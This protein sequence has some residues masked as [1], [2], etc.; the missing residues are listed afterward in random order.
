MKRILA[1]ILFLSIGL[2]SY[3]QK[4]II[5]TLFVP[6][7]EKFSNVQNQKLKF[8]LIKTGNSQIDNSINKDLKD[9]FTNNEFPSLP[10]DSAIIKWADNGIIYLGFEVTYVRNGLLS[11]NISAEGCGAYC[12]GWTDYFTYNH[13][14]GKYVTI[15]EI[16]DTTEKFRT[17]VLL[18]KNKQFEQQK[19][20]LKKMLL[21]KDAELDEETYKWV[22]E[23]FETCEKEFSLNTFALYNDHLEIVE[24]CY[25]PNAIKSFT[26]TIELKYKYVDINQY[27]KIKN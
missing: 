15:D 8:P 10:T 13:K 20:E 1:T 23:H 26:P 27:L 3:G 5:D 17:L 16:V 11:F 7:T 9:R 12:T 19:N 2:T 22:L 18:E 24:K 6:R 14:T 4:I 21:D 25:L